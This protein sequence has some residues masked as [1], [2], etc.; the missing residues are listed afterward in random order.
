MNTQKAT[1][2]YETLATTDAR[3][4]LA[5][6][7]ARVKYTRKRIVLT[8]HGRREAVLIPVEDLDILQALDD[9]RLHTEA[10]AA[11]AE[12]AGKY[13]SHDDVLKRVARRRSEATRRSPK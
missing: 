8:K 13:V 7:V 2:E 10:Q 6:V 3:R 11:I 9:E 1:G 12:T 5:D 4:G